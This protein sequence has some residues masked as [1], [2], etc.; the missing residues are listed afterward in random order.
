MSA[1]REIK[2]RIKSARN[3]GQVT[4]ALQMVSAVKMR[5]AQ[6][7]ASQG[8]PYADFLAE[9]ILSLTGEAEV[10]HPFLVMPTKEAKVLMVVIGPSKGLAG[11]LIS[12][13]NKKVWEFVNQKN[14]EVVGVS[15]GKKGR[16]S[17]LRS[18]VTLEADFGSVKNQVLADQISALTT[19]IDDGF[20][21]G[22]YDLVYVIYNRFVNTMEQEPT[23][24]QLLP[25]V[26]WKGQAEQV[27]VQFTFEPSRSM[28]LDRLLDHYLKTT[29]R[30]IIFDSIASEHS[31]RMVAMKNANENATEIISELSLKYNKTRQA[32][33]TSEIAD[34]ISGVLGSQQV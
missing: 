30:Q 14:C 2:R 5:R 33:V 28:I 29:L 8:R 32:M 25:A 10:K 20:R 22:K 18:N 16:E 26:T 6:M 24:W 1:T 11:P 15:F 21:A 23:V 19:Y 13:L 9:A 31:A 7:A 4:K 3:I 17:I 27:N 34:I 12:G